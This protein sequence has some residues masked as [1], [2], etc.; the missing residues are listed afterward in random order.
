MFI[1]SFIKV[2]T[3]FADTFG[4]QFVISLKNHRHMFPEFLIQRPEPSVSNSAIPTEQCDTK[5]QLSHQ[6]SQ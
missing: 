4:N 6:R 3:H 2:D 1:N 5:A